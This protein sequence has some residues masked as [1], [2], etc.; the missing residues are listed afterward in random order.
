MQ[1]LQIPALDGYSLAATRYDALEASDK[2]MLICSANGVLQRFYRDI[3]TFWT[4]LGYTVY[5]FDY[6]G[7]GDSR[8]ASLRNFQATI[9]TWGEQDAS[10]ILQY[11]FDQHPTA[12]VDILAHSIGGQ[13]L[14]LIKG[15]ERVRRLAIVASSGGYVGHWSGWGKAKLLF[16]WYVGIPMLSRAFGYLP[17]K[18]LRMF[19]DLPK[20]VALEWAKWGRHS[21]YMMGYLTEEQ[22]RPYRTLSAPL[23][24]YTFSDDTFCPLPAVQWLAR[25]YQ[26]A[27]LTHKHYQPRDFQLPSIGHFNFFRKKYQPYFWDEVAAFFQ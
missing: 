18:R 17:A 12:S 2:I 5:T 14:G 13:I 16:N 20:G 4:T 6:R 21:E 23:L 8:P 27:Q 24:L 9:Q 25:Q 15:V 26:A 1:T 3:A 11:I 7:I 19:E 22:A 10:G